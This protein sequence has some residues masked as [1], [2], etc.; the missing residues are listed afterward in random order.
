[1][2]A[3]SLRAKRVLPCYACTGARQAVGIRDGR[4]P[5]PRTA[6]TLGADRCSP[7]LGKLHD[8]SAVAVPCTFTG[9]IDVGVAMLGAAINVI[10]CCFLTV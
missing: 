3:S 9:A 4:T 8:L 2:D 10:S 6:V 7:L 5:L 1:M